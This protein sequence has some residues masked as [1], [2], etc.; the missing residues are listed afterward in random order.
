ML[1]WLP[2]QVDED[3]DGEEEIIEEEEEVVTTTKVT[4]EE[5]VVEDEEDQ[6]KFGVDGLGQ[7]TQEEMEE[8]MMLQVR[9]LT[10]H[11]FIFYGNIKQ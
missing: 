3:E 11:T 9:V 1:S 10:F 8:F 6:D 4:K 2:S 5:A 7:L